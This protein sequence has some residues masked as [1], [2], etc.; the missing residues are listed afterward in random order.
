MNEFIE[1][2]KG[3]RINRRHIVSYQVLCKEEL[4]YINF[5]MSDG[6]KMSTDKFKN[7]YEAEEFIKKNQL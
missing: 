6:A 3:N 2:Q 4:L 1:I 7:I 5:N